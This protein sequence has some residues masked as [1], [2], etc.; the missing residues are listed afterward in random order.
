MKFDFNICSVFRIDVRKQLYYNANH[1]GCGK[2][3]DLHMN[4]MNEFYLTCDETR[5]LN[6]VNDPAIRPSLLEH[7]EKLGLLSAFL[8]AENGTTE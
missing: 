1:I 5:F 6:L 4:Q 8:E 7:L 3:C 2:E